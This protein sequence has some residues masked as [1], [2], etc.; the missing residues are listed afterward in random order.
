MTC[1]SLDQNEV[2]DIK[3][4]HDD[5]NP[6]AQ[7]AMDR[8]NRD[9]LY[10]LMQA[11]GTEPT[12]ILLVIVHWSLPPPLSGIS[13]MNT[14][15]QYPAE[16]SLPA[17]KKMKLDNGIDLLQQHPELAYPDTDQQYP[18]TATAPLAALPEGVSQE[19]YLQAWAN[20]AKS[21]EQTSPQGAVADP[22]TT[23]APPAGSSEQEGPSS[24]SSSHKGNAPP[25]EWVEVLDDE[26]GATY[27]Y[28]PQTGETS[29]GVAPEE[30]KDGELEEEDE[31]STG[32][33][34]KESS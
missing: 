9:A 12:S 2:L 6:V 18:A 5:P 33:K 17:A 14:G 8:A 1:Q 10:A 30:E 25:G 16:Y 4:A 20:Y 29:W 34:G 11:K 22:A 32:D 3:W 19:E 23:S 24:G 26:T 21:L 13:L 27:Y 15:F 31:E 28:N 7:D